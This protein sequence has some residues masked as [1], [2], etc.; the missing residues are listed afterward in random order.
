MEELRPKQLEEPA[1]HH[2]GA[3]SDAVIV[4]PGRDLPSGGV[5]VGGGQDSS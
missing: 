4:A 3:G 2:G 5:L 1:P